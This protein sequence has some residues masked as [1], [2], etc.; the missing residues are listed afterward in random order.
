MDDISFEAASGMMVN[1]CTV[2]SIWLSR[3]MEA[4]LDSE[5]SSLAS[6]FYR[7]GGNTFRRPCGHSE[8]RPRPLLAIERNLT[9]K[10]IYLL[11]CVFVSG[12][13]LFPG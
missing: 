13:L 9:R 10:T 6:L 7:P 2:L 1:V 3:K 5:V 12:V 11:S 4:R 8:C